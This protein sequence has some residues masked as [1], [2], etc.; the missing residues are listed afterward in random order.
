MPAEHEP[1]N[2]LGNMKM[3]LVVQETKDEEELK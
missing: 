3:S 1:S 2:I